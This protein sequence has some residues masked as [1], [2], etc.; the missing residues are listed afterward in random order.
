M[1]LLKGLLSAF[2]QPEWYYYQQGRRRGPVALIDLK[3]LIEE[4]VV[5]GNTDVWR[6]GMADWERARSVPEL[7]DETR[8]Q[9]VLADGW[10]EVAPRPTDH[11]VAWFSDAGAPYHIKVSET[12]F[13]DSRQFLSGMWCWSLV[14]EGR[15]PNLYCAVYEQEPDASPCSDSGSSSI[16]RVH[17]DTG[18]TK[19]LTEAPRGHTFREVLALLPGDDR[20]VSWLSD[21]GNIARG[22][23]SVIE[24]E[25]AE[26]H[27]V[28]V[29]DQLPGFP[30]ALSARHRSVL[31]AGFGQLR[32]IDF[33][34]E[35]VADFREQSGLDFRGGAVNESTGEIAVWAEQYRLKPGHSRPVGRGIYL[36]EP[37]A[38][39]L[40]KVHD[41]GKSLAWSVDDRSLWFYGTDAN[42]WRLSLD[43][44]EAERIV[45]LG[46]DGAVSDEWGTD[47]A[48]SADGRCVLAHLSTKNRVS[49][50]EEQYRRR[51]V[52]GCCSPPDVLLTHDYSH[53]FCVVDAQ[54]KEVWQHSGW[55]REA[56][57]VGPVSAE[58][59]DGHRRPASTG[60]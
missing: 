40:D 17:V 28:P 54:E 12:N 30:C 47:I 16:M 48:V 2:E 27:D 4:G 49:E 3:I 1:R 33:E 23:I 43:S 41:G 56:A 14:H 35:I 22:H 9:L 20:L 15:S 11:M 7:R 25:S 58:P 53:Y 59:S 55:W 57:W 37:E 18:E 52:K 39:R 10:S 5:T 34:G 60:P 31:F 26:R 45:Q 44:L 50:A 32:L 51:Q 13:V 46:K 6:P 38:S 8:A 19:K 29:P 24:A 36:W 21:D 42:L